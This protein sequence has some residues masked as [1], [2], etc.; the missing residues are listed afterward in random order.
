MAAAEYDAAEYDAAE[1]DA[2]EYDAAV[3]DAFRKRMFQTF[4][5]GVVT[6]QVDLAVRT[7]LLDALAAGPGTSGEL[8]TRA[9]LHERHVRECLGTLVTA[10]IVDYDAATLTYALPA[11]H[12]AV[13]TGGGS[14]NV[15]P[16]ARMMALLAPHVPAVATAF[17]EGGGVPYDAYRPEFTTVMDG[18]SRGQMDGQLL[19][20]ILPLAVGLKERM[21]AGLRAADVGCG[22]GHALNL[23]AQ[24]FP[25]STFVG[26][27]FAA[28]A[29][30]A[31]RAEAAS[32]GLTNVAF[33]VHDVTALPTDPPFDVV[34][35][36]DAIHDQRDPAAVLAAIHAVLVPGGTFAMMDIRGHSALEDNV[37]NPFAPLLYGVSTLH[38]MQVSLALGG[39]GLGTMWGEQTARRMLADAGFGPVEVFPVPENPMDSFY[40]TGKPRRDDA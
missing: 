17:R 15:A 28:D 5:G 30:E 23:M 16:L 25:A 32:M 12:A 37:G 19:D 7:G 38:C 29:V 11:A 21:A 2:A 22:T 1:Y 18:L 13:L 24:A 26:F 27:D 10:A 40:V 8:A 9:G 35:A 4:S 34:F 6:L 39:A 36:F 14:G 31:A 20:G 3:A 33:E